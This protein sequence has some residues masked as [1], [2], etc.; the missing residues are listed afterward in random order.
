MLRK[1]FFLNYTEFG[2]KI[3]MILLFFYH[4]MKV[5]VIE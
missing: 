2:F 3:Q 1:R 5:A 4:L